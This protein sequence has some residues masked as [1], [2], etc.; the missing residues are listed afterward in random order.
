MGGG[1]RGGMEAAVCVQT[2]PSPPAAGGGAGG[3]RVH[4]W[5]LG[6]ARGL[7]LCEVSFILIAAKACL[8]A[9]PCAPALGLPRGGAVSDVHRKAPCAP[10]APK[11]YLGLPVS[12][13]N[14]G[15]KEDL[16]GAQGTQLTV[17]HPTGT[18]TSF[19][20]I[21]DPPCWRPLALASRSLRPL[22]SARA[23][24]PAPWLL[25]HQPWTILESLRETLPG[26]KCPPAQ[27]KSCPVHAFLQ[28]SHLHGHSVSR[29]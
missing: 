27:G 9:M 21:S 14:L 2:E 4:L 12:G 10:D 5:A 29:H 18:R 19:F 7:P 3:Q 20:P 13:Q 16:G 23:E 22:P 6:T 17:W 8:T 15:G 11:L 24:E 26:W 1:Q 28:R 25:L